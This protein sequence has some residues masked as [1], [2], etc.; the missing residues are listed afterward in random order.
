MGDHLWPPA[1][2]AGKRIFGT[3][4]GIHGVDFSWFGFLT[5]LD[6]NRLGF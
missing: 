5:G 6:F 1:A 4:D 2:P 3:A